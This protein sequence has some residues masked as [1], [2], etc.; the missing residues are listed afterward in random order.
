MGGTASRV[1][2]GDAPSLDLALNLIQR[3]CAGDILTRT[4]QRYPGKTAIVD[5]HGGRTLT[6]AELNR[7]ANR[8]GRALLGLGL[9]HQDKVAIMA[10]NTWQFVVTYF[11]CAKAGLI[12]MPVN[13]GLRPEEIGYVLHDAGARVVV[14]EGIFRTA[15]EAAAS[16]LP[17]IQR[18]Y[19]TEVDPAT[20]FTAGH[21]QFLAFDRLLAGPPAQASSPGGGPP[22]GGGPRAGLDPDD[23]E[24]EVFI[25]DR[26]TVQCLYTSGTTSL[27]KGVLTSHLAVTITA[28]ASAVAN[29]SDPD[30]VLL[31]VLPI[32]HCAALNA[33]L[34]PALLVGATAV[35]LRKYDVRDVMDALERHRVTHVLLL[36]M[37]WQ[38]LLQQP[39]VR[40]RDFSSVRRCLYAMAPMAPERIAEIQ[41]L[42][43]NADVVLGS[44]QTEFTP[45]TVFQRPHHQHTKP[46]SWGLPTVMTDVRIMDDQGRLLPRGQVGEIV[47]RGPQCM[48]AYWNNPEA[49]AE[50]FRH[51]WFHSGD[52]GWMDEEGVVWFTDRKKD[53]VKTG[54][55]N[56]ASIEVERA[57]LAHPAVAECA[58]VGLPHDRW[59]EAVTAFVLLKPGSQATEEELIAHCRERLAG[60]KVPKRVVFATEFPR[61]GTGKIQKHVLRQQ[62]RDLYQG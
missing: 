35:F 25:A 56:V 48:T 20:E 44:G 37:M 34:L 51:G 12:A 6:Y 59:G 15:L 10:R 31:L 55:E 29:K 62:H 26:D 7:Y 21:V 5:I 19:L 58:V 54:G 36:P 40:E 24:L 30:D 9:G 32:F 52:V 28:L 38:E 61:T 27:P 14:A 41:A 2:E 50:A 43:P 53:M 17:A 16:R 13:L 47:Y 33:L 39:G 11:A 3:V 46:A 4:A 22:G 45:P 49:T 23:A 1:R 42:F 8:V 18:V 57:L 60:F